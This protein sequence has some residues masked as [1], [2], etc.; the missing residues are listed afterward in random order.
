MILLKLADIY[1]QRSKYEEAKQ[2]C[3]K[4]LGILIET[5]NNHGVGICYGNLGAVFR[6]VGQYTKAEEYLQ[7]ALVISKKIGDKQGEAS[8]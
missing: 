4:A 6:S 8:T 5:G 1:Y 7:N 3:E 2:C